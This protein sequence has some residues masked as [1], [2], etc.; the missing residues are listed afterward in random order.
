MRFFW[1]INEMTDARAA[2]KTKGALIALFQT[3]GDDL[4]P[5]FQY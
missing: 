3:R 2:G 5:G 4:P 1:F